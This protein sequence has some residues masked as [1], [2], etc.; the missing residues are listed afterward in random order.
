MRA[1]I[2]SHTYSDPAHRGKLQA[3]VGQGAALAVAVPARW[4]PPGTSESVLTPF[5]EDNGVRI[6][7]IPTSGLQNGGTP[8]SWRPGEIR[9]L[10]TDFRPAIV[11]VEEEPTTR[12]AASATRVARQ[13]GIP[14]VAFT[15]DSL[16]RSYPLLP[17]LRR[18]R[19]L[20]RAAAILGTNAVA[21][22]IV[23]TEFPGLAWESIPQLGLPVP[24]APATEPHAPLSIGFVG[25]LIPEKGLD[26]LLRACVRLYGAWTLTVAGTGPAQEE[27]EAL[28]E[29][30]GIASRVTWLGG[31]PRSELASLW[32]RLDCLVAPSRT[33]ARWVETYP[34]QVLE[35]MGHGVAVVVSDSGALPESVGRAGLVFGDGH[36]DGLTE[37]LTRLLED[38]SLR[39]RLAAEGRRRVIAEFVDDAIARKTLAFWR[40]VR[41]GGGS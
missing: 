30:L 1:V 38:G 3:L 18:R 13:L 23:R 21:T 32:P 22:G 24:R 7:P 25:R 39:E 19:T 17:R 16:L 2:I 20:S 41:E 14:A 6:V 29:R 5:A 36:P 40:A 28:A 27:L 8:V 9:R 35:A 34:L 37:A 31:I 12:V 15:A 11:Q 10:L 33:T 26:V 4:T